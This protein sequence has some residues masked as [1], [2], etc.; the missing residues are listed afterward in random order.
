VVD[1]INALSIE[2]LDFLGDDLLDF[3]S[4][5]DLTTWLDNQG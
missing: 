4:I 2:Q 5:D 1:R 3:G